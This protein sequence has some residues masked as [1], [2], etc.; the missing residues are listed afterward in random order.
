MVSKSGIVVC[1]YAQECIHRGRETKMEIDICDVI[2]LISWFIFLLF[3]AHAVNCVSALV[4]KT[5]VDDNMFVHINEIISLC[6]DV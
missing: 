1:Q 5:S 3:Y 2:S 4:E 6:K